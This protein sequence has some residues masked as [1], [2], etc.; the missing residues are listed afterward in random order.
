MFKTT[1]N[2][3]KCQ[4]GEWA[5]TRSALINPGATEA[6]RVRFDSKDL[7]LAVVFAALYATL[8]IAQGQSAAATIQLRIADCLIP[9]C[10]LFGWPAIAGVSVGALAGNAFTSLPMS[11]G[12]CDVVFG[13][14]ANLLAGVI[15]YTL[16]RRR[17]M[18]CVLASVE[19]G[20][21]V[22][23]YV[24]MIFGAPSNIFSVEIPVSWSFWAASVV[25]IT[26]SSLVAIALIGY[27]L[28]SILSRESIAVPL[29]SRGLRI[30]S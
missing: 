16:R 6:R 22:G 4:A 7:A 19:V 15:M 11:N 2:I 1:G 25:S 20:L 13:P 12:V 24:W 5:S 9:L 23:S 3:L 26:M 18:G 28:L 10:A 17:L 29:K 30:V 14:L 27:A 21:V 8:V